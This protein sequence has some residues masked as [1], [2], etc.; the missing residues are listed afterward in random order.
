MPFN[1]RGACIEAIVEM[2]EQ[3]YDLS[4]ISG[5]ANSLSSM[6]M[7]L[8]PGLASSCELSF[9]PTF[10][11]AKKL[12]ESGILGTGFPPAGGNE[13]EGF[14]SISGVMKS[15]ANVGSL[16]KLTGAVVGGGVVASEKGD[17]SAPSPIKDTAVSIKVRWWYEDESETSISP[18][19]YGTLQPPSFS[20]GESIT[21]TMQAVNTAA[22]TAAGFQSSDSH[23]GVAVTSVV[24]KIAD[25]IGVE[26]RWRKNARSI[27]DSRR[28]QEQQDVNLLV[29]L[30]EILEKI[31][32][33]AYFGHDGEDD[34]EMMHIISHEDLNA[35][36]PVCTL[37]MYSQIDPAGSSPIYP[38]SGCDTNISHAFTGIT[39]GSVQ[40]AV[41]PKTKKIPAPSRNDSSTYERTNIGD[42]MGGKSPEVSSV[43]GTKAKLSND[44]IDS[45]FHNKGALVNGDH[46]EDSYKDGQ[47]Y[48]NDSMEK[49]WEMTLHGP[50]IPSLLPMSLVKVNIG[51]IRHL[52]GLYKIRSIE[53]VVD[54]NGAESSIT[55]FKAV[56]M[57]SPDQLGK[58]ENTKEPSGSLGGIN[59]LSKSLSGGIF[60]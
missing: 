16:T 32:C 1:M 7:K 44:S 15:L 38:I 31:G 40:A 6:R 24:A 22:N 3:S 43:D 12:I 18:V 49:A 14:T 41:D 5:A 59:A 30:N 48:F 51:N 56:G 13:L 11:V 46:P 58:E 10:D 50:A 19:F 39:T 21:I 20:F 25:K 54:T 33:F 27:A 42:T 29:Y 57:N 9:T 2:G 52:T 17:A 23:D 4:V 34:G 35:E 53:H 47:N 60:A 8:E 28:V 37:A 26:V 55:V 36:G 45:G